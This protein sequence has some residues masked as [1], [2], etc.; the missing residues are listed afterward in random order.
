M[1]EQ[2]LVVHDVQC[3]DTTSDMC[4]LLATWY[5]SLFLRKARIGIVSGVLFLVLHGVAIGGVDALAINGIDVVV[6]IGCLS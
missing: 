1:E 6:A 5:V 4:H 2:Q 3:F